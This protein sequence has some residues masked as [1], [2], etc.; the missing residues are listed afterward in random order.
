[1]QVLEQRESILNSSNEIFEG[2]KQQ[3]E[4]INTKLD[5][6][7]PQSFQIN[8]VVPNFL[9]VSQLLPSLY[10]C[11]ASV[12]TPQMLT[13]LGINFVINVASELPDTPLPTASK[14]LYL[15]IN[16]SDSTHTDLLK[17]FD[18]VSEMIEEIRRNGGK[19]LVH[20]VAGVS[21]S[22]TLCLAYL[23]KYGQMNLKDA[24]LHVKSIRP[25]IRPNSAFIQQLRCYEEQLLG[26]QSVK[27]IFMECL[28][29]E[30]PDVYEAEYRAMEDFYQR[31]RTIFRKR[32]E[33]KAI[34][35]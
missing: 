3:V 34:K 21:R 19:T 5:E 28:Q 20:C 13:Q 23:M 26:L 33:D 32:Q 22:A 6:N 18:E 35:T 4:G 17:H 2:C 1:M 12:I 10:L 16:V 29:K 24:F 25:Q 30:I 11:G 31:Q 15:R 7:K 8:P 27:M 9:G 14:I